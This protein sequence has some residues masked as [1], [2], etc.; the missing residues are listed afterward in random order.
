MKQDRRGFIVIEATISMT[1]L[2]FFMTLLLSLISVVTLQA[3][4]HFAITQTAITISRYSYIFEVTGIANRLVHL[5]AGSQGRRD[6]IRG[7]VDTTRQS[8]NAAGDFIADISDRDNLSLEDGLEIADDALSNVMPWIENPDAFVQDVNRLIDATRTTAGNMV[9][10]SVHYLWRFLT[11]AMVRPLIGHYLNNGDMSGDQYLISA[12][13]IGGLNGLRFSYPDHGSFLGNLWGSLTGEGGHQTI[14]L[15]RYGNIQIF[16]QYDVE[17]FFGI[18]PLPFTRL[19]INQS[20]T[21][22]AWLSG[23]HTRGD[24]AENLVRTGY[25]RVLDPRRGENAWGGVTNQAEYTREGDE[26]AF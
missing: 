20:V 24:V 26:D 15:D 11:E 10:E 25:V 21:T 23:F 18:L 9:T 2:I 7:A 5:D 8:I 6:Q 1:L 12:N 22:K 13:V 3:R 4:M 16:V 19:T 14:I 17:L